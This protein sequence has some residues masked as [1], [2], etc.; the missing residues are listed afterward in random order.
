[1]AP[2]VADPHPGRPLAPEE[3][4]QVAVTPAAQAG[5]ALDPAGLPH[6]A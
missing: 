3:A 1:M 4:R 6:Q 5:A 2:R